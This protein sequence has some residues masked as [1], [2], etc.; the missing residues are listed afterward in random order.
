M[1][2]LPHEG[3]CRDRK[4]AALLDCRAHYLR[5]G[6]LVQEKSAIGAAFFHTL[7]RCD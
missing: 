4:Q 1:P 5:H 7:S 6:D 3:F 2:G